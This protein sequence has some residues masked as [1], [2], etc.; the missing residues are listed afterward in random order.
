ML[1]ELSKII[2]FSLLAF[3]LAFI[4]YPWYI[5]FLKH[6]K[7]GKAI[8]E[9]SV[10]GTKAEIFQQLHS[11]KAGTPTMGGGLFLVILIVMIGISY[12]IKYYGHTT[13]SL[14]TRQETYILL[15]AFFGM[16]LL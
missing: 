1:G 10:T 14:V 12:L 5:R 11:H 6:V 9:E 15:F 8:R 3:A 7:A 13:Y 16:G 2:L 4:V